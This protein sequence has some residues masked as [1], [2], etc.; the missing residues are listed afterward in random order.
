MQDHLDNVFH[1]PVIGGRDIHHGSLGV[2]LGRR[3]K[4]GGGEDGEMRRGGGG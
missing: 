4:G 3:G 2:G 1:R